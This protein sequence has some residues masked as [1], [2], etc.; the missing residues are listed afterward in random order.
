LKLSP[1]FLLSS[2]LLTKR[3]KRRHGASL[4]SSAETSVVYGRSMRPKFCFRYTYVVPV[5]RL[6]KVRL[7]REKKGD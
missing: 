3:S 6:G 2:R 5:R 7:G 1:S 4:L